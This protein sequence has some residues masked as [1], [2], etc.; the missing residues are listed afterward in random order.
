MLDDLPASKR[1]PRGLTE[2]VRDPGTCAAR[3][4]CGAAHA[5]RRMV[6]RL[7]A[8]RLSVAAAD[9]TADRGRA[10]WNVAEWHGKTLVSRNAEK[11]GQLPDVFV[12]IETAQPQFAAAKEDIIGRHPTFVLLRRVRVR[13]GELLLAATGRSDFYR[14]PDTPPDCHR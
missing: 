3:S 6:G 4:A 11:I 14:V 7:G 2:P 5:H 10:H 9:M 12:D 8:V 1:D 13:P